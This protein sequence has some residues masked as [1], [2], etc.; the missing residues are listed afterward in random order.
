MKITESL[1]STV[2]RVDDCIWEIPP[3]AKPG[4]LVPARL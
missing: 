2:K 3:E 4:M 1:R